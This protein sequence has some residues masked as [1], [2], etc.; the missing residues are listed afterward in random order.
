MKVSDF[1]LEGFLVGFF[2]SNMHA[3][4]E[5][6][7]SVRQAKSIG[8]TNTK[9]MLA[10]LQQSIFRAKLAEKS[11]VF[12]DVGFEWILGRFWKR[13]GRPKSLIFAIFSRK[14][15]SK[16]SDDFW[17]AKKSHFEASRANCG[18]SAAVCAGPGEG[19]KGWGKAL[20]VGI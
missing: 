5:T 13:F 11:H 18:R 15:G 9:S 12:W 4:S 17:K 6:K 3:N 14:N 19:T 10:L 8:K 2:L 7:K 20:E 16:K 1:V